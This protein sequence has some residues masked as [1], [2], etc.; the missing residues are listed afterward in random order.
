MI[1][2]YAGPDRE[3][4]AQKSNDW[5]GQ[6]DQRYVNPDFDALYEELV[7]QT[8]PESAYQILI[9]M[10]DVLIN[11]VV[12]VPEV[13]R[14]ADKYAISNNLRNENVAEST[15]EFDYWNLANWNRP[16]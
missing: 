13:N 16:A 10:N 2:W 14:A 8:D 1:R 7:K 9:E 4:V 5:Q 15:F 6:N 3:N 11:D 12:I